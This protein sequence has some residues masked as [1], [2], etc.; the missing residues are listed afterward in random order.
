[1]YSG[2][3]TWTPYP[4][5]KYD[6]AACK[7][8]FQ[9][10]AKRRPCPLC[11]AYTPHGHMD[12]LNK[13]P[14]G[15]T[16][17]VNA[18][19]D[20]AFTPLEFLQKIVDAVRKNALAHPGK[21]FYFQTKNPNFSFNRLV[22]L[23][24]GLED[25]V[26]LLITLETNRDEGYQQYSKAPYP[27]TRWITFRAIDWPHKIVTIEP[28]MDFDLEPFY[29]ILME[30]HPEAV[31]IGYNSHPK[32][33]HL[34]EPAWPKVKHLIEDLETAGIEVR[35]K[36]LRRTSCKARISDCACA[37]DPSLVPENDCPCNM[38]SA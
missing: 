34:P 19:G 29:K 36:D 3:R 4:G 7:P 13:I 27:S 35:P 21:L 33:V 22:P 16:I 8:T 2:V 5:C 18:S 25:Q 31:Y 12:R 30:L 20:I 26:T 10:Q 15:K 17:F 14:A 24:K 32:E 9:R 6:C 23:L 28:L 37:N 11:K 1:M 38:W